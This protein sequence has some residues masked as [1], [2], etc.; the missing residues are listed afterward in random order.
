MNEGTGY[1]KSATADAVVY[2]GYGEN[3]WG[4]GRLV[5]VESGGEVVGPLLH[6]V[7]HSRTGMTWG[8][9]GLG[10]ADLARSLLIHA[11][12]DAARCVVCDGTSEVVYDKAT[13]TYVPAGIASGPRFSE[14]TRC[15][16]CEDGWNVMSSTYQRFKCDVVAQLPDDGWR[17]TRIEVLAWLD[18]HATTASA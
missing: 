10:P 17:L 9:D 1:V 11:L 13:D 5:A 18:Q 16:A 14:P 8:Y 4:G 15:A 12:G 7:K 3:R 2:R 6:H